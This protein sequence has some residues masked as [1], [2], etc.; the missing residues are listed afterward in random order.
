MPNPSPLS[1]RPDRRTVL[2]AA[3]L[4]AAAIPLAACS[5]VEDPLAA[6]ARAGN[7]KNYIAGD[8]SVEEYAADSRGG[9]VRL[10][11]TTYDG[12]SVDSGAWAGQ[13]TV[14][15][16]W[17]AA[18]APCRVEAPHMAELSAEFADKGVQFFG[19]NVR[20]EQ[21]TAAA[22]ERTFGIEYPSMPDRDGAILLAMTDFVPPQAVPTTLVIDKQGRVAARI[23]GVAEKGTLKTL[24]ADRVSETA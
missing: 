2:R 12:E 17:Y 21:P 5:A 18:C 1:P 7:N 3:A 23:L 16:F 10:A 22:F 11:G 14:L 8:G 15:N 4:F 24:I 6:Q 9:A 19:V 20:D 13:V